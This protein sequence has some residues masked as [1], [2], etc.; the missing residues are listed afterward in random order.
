M[1]ESRIVNSAWSFSLI[2]QVLMFTDISAKYI[3]LPFITHKS[4]SVQDLFISYVQSCSWRKGLSFCFNFPA[5]KVLT[6]I[7]PD[8]LFNGHMILVWETTSFLI[9][10]AVQI[11]CFDCF[12]S[13]LYCTMLKT[14]CPYSFI[15]FPF[16]WITA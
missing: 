10:H 1:H 3:N 11:W 12:H 9:L 6:V 2:F 4:Q 14:L 13:I 7:T 16:L 5:S 15:D 8:P